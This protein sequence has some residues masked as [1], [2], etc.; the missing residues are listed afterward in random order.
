LPFLLPFRAA[1]WRPQIATWGDRHF[2]SGINAEISARADI[3][4]ATASALVIVTGASK[5]IRQSNL[6]LFIGLI[7]RPT[8]AAF[9]LG[10]CDPHKRTGETQSRLR[11]W[12]L[13]VRG[14][15][16]ARRV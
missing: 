13:T 8:C 11:N 5:S 2:P 15:V 10:D 16:G 12:A 7:D 3:S 9:W 14:Q 4:A 1:S 6:F